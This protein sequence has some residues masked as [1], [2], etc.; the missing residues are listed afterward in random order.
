MA[1]QGIN[2]FMT[3]IANR[4]GMSLTTGFDVEF[5]FPTLENDRERFYGG[6]YYNI[7]NDTKDVV[8][9]LCDEAQLPLSLIHI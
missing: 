3:K 1:V 8:T 4:G 7:T 6:Q 5:A 9:M 2:D